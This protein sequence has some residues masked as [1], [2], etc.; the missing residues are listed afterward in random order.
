ME[1]SNVCSTSII[2][3]IHILTSPQYTFLEK[4]ENMRCKSSFRERK[5][6]KEDPPF[7]ANPRT[8]KMLWTLDSCRSIVPRSQFDRSTCSQMRRSNKINIIFDNSSINNG[9]WG[10][11]LTLLLV[12]VQISPLLTKLRIN[13]NAFFWC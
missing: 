1:K 2:H 12:V 13:S 7:P 10:L 4:P 8:L 5:R 6:R 9:W 11:L 3:N